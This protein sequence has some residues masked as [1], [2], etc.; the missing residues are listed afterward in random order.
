MRLQT[1]A[2]SS[3]SNILEGAVAIALFQLF[4][5]TIL[6]WFLFATA[7]QVTYQEARRNEQYLEF[8]NKKSTPHQ[9]LCDMLVRWYLGKCE[10]L[11]I[12]VG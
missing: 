12:I 8:N 2:L 6:K 3:I 10:T 4:L 9:N 5:I 11:N 1:T 7:F